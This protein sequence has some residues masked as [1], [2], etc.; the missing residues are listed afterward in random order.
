M[1]P[2]SREPRQPHLY[3]GTDTTAT[4]TTGLGP[5]AGVENKDILNP[6][7]RF[8]PDRPARIWPSRR[9]PPSDGSEVPQPSPPQIGVASSSCPSP[10]AGPDR[11]LGR[12]AWSAAG[13]S[14]GTNVP[15]RPTSYTS[16]PGLNVDAFLV[17]VKEETASPEWSEDSESVSDEENPEDGEIP[18]RGNT[19]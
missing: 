13:E 1:F 16:P 9:C 6:E 3:Y 8:T 4:G 19:F 18:H 11:K 7:A 12:R 2:I 15:T 10:L 14:V 17:Q 5:A